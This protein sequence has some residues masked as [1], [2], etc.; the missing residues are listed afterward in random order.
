M[1]TPSSPSPEGRRRRTR[2]LIVTASGCAGI[3]ATQLRDVGFT[4][5]QLRAGYSVAQL[6]TAGFSALELRAAGV[7]TAKLKAAGFRPDQLLAPAQLMP[8]P[9]PPSI[10]KPFALARSDSATSESMAA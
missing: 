9:N 3:T 8:P 2:L 7:P 5:A 10:S 1:R 4:A 6:K